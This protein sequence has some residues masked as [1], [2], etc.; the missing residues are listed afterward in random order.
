MFELGV[1]NLC[2]LIA[3]QLNADRCVRCSSTLIAFICDLIE[4]SVSIQQQLVQN[5]G[6]LIISYLLE[7]VRVQCLLFQD[8]DLY[9]VAL[10]R[11]VANHYKLS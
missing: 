11:T 5:K 8:I 4:S 3:L 7:K 10:S 1:L 9:T 6:F 2:T